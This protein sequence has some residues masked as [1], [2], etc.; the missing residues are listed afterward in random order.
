MI[1]AQRDG[2]VTHWSRY[3]HESLHLLLSYIPQVIE[4]EVVMIGEDGIL[5]LASVR[6]SDAGVYS[7]NGTNSLGTAESD[8]PILLRIYCEYTNP[9]ITPNYVVA[10]HWQS[11]VLRKLW[12]NG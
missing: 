5:V 4:S 7:C 10:D 11:N 6:L 8:I 9:V 1:R 2:P 12:W 3:M